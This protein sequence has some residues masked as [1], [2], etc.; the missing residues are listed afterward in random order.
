MGLTTNATAFWLEWSQMGDGLGRGRREPV[1]QSLSASLG[2]LGRMRETV[3][4]TKQKCRMFLATNLPRNRNR[5]RGRNFAGVQS[6]Y[7]PS[8]P[9]SR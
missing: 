1:H 6:V 9:H 3:I 8:L 7:R 2:G 5:N 4:S